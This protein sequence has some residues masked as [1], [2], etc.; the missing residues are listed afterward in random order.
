MA[1][2]IKEARTRAERKAFIAFQNQLYRDVPQYVPTLMMDEMANLNP[3]KNP[4]FEFCEMKLFLCLRDGEIV[5][6][7]CAIINHASNKKWQ[8]KR[9]RICRLDF[10]DDP[11]VS[12]ML[13]GAAEAWGREKGMTEMVGPLGFCDF[14]KEGMLIDGF[15]R[16]GMFIT[17]YNFPYYIT[18]MERLGFTKD[19]DWLENKVYVN[20]LEPE[21]LSRICNR[22]LERTGARIVDI[23][24]KKQLRP[25]VQRV[26]EMV[27]REYAGLYGFTPLTK[28]QMH[29]YAGQFV[30]MLNVRYI[31]IME[32]AQGE[33]AAIGVLAPSFAEAVK[34]NKGRMFPFG[35]IPMLRAIR[36]PKTLDMYFVAVDS[37]YRKSGLNAVLLHEM[38]RRA[39]EDGIL[40][41]ETGPELEENYGVQGMWA[42]YQ[43]DQNH[44]RRRC[45]IKPIA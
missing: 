12:E 26:I 19:V 36:R 33:L 42:G 34:K 27:D 4:A 41:A 21:K 20:C 44:K 18:H 24:T 17:Y 3:Q 37:K 15:D 22:V 25:Y 45:W 13:I 14:D 30:S 7:V 35:W 32:D 28:R 29:Y 8:Q 16:M 6:R 10:I 31:V 1:L 9:I 11:A 38:T 39:E 43:V 23:R 5:G 40:Y 2:T